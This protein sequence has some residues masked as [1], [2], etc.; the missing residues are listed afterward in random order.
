MRL[1][2]RYLNHRCYVEGC[3]DRLLCCYHAFFLCSPFFLVR[4]FSP[5]RANMDVENENR[6]CKDALW[7]RHTHTGVVLPRP[8]F[9]A[10]FTTKSQRYVVS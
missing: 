2:D 4:P 1:L 10:L 3:S 6:P 9:V 8:R 7:D 5:G